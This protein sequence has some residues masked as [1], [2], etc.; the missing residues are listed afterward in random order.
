M[1]GGNGQSM[2][3]NLRNINSIKLHENCMPPEFQVEITIESKELVIIRS[4]QTLL[5]AKIDFVNV[6]TY[7]LT[8]LC[9]LQI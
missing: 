4:M 2:Q 6:L 7:L 5:E 8:F 1:S 9:Y 3:V